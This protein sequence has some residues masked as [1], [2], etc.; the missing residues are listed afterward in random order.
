MTDLDHLRAELAAVDRTLLE[1]VA[2][3]Q[4]LA[5]QIGRVKAAAGVPV[6]DFRQ[7]RDV[8]E[9]ARAAAAERGLAPSI[10][11]EL[12][13]TLIRASLAAQERDR[14]AATGSG[15]GRRVLVIGG[16]GRMGRWFARFLAAQGFAVEIADPAGPVDGFPSVADWRSTPLEHELI[17]VAAPMPVTAAILGELAA[18]PPPGVI[19]DVG[20]LK[21]P[22]RAS[23]AALVAAGGRVTSVHPMFGP[24]TELLSGRHV[25]FV[26]VG[27]PAATA[28]AR[29]LFASTMATVVEMDLESHDRLIAYVLGLS[30]ALNL[31]FFTALADS[32]EAAPRLATLS[33][34]TFDAQLRI[35]AAVAGENPDLYFEIQHGNDYGAESLAALSYAVERIRSVVRAGD[36]AGFR[37]LM[38]RGR[39]YL[40]TRAR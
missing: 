28:A 23:L 39:D 15:S 1:A 19:F 17:V 27:V 33:S 2:R 32:G 24:D 36:G 38:T 21:S 5:Q 3:R 18:A 40:A 4:E 12:M 8:I 13:L 9:R 29:E 35:A 30:H 14:V 10:G 26:D 25:I 37:A 22:L 16:A 31:A 20:S 6:R 7:E 11:E 34:T